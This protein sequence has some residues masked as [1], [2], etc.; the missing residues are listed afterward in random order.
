MPDSMSA[1]ISA[2]DI[3]PN[4]PVTVHVIQLTDFARDLTMRAQIHTPHETLL[5]DAGEA[6]GLVLLPLR[7]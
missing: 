4:F 1:L 7:V 6:A 2:R 5:K 3:P